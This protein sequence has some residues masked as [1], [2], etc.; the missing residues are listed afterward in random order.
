V[1][2]EADQPQH[3]QH[4]NNCPKHIQFSSFVSLFGAIVGADW[5]FVDESFLPRMSLRQTGANY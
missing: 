1:H 2:Q 5:A 4:R 3:K